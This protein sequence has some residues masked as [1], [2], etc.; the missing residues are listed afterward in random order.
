MFVCMDG[1]F[2]LYIVCSTHSDCWLL[3]VIRCKRYY[4]SDLQLSPASLSLSLSF[5]HSFSITWIK[6]SVQTNQNNQ[7]IIQA[8]KHTALDISMKIKL[9]CLSVVLVVSDKTTLSLFAD[10]SAWFWMLRSSRYGTHTRS[11]SDKVWA[12][13]ELDIFNKCK[14]FYSHEWILN[15]FAKISI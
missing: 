9:Y 14:Q 13:G 15:K 11:Y 1:C 12:S 4:A 8:Y 5:Y 2:S 3:H 6:N 7:P 10:V